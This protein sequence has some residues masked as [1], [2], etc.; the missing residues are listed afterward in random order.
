MD[1]D[2][3]AMLVLVTGFLVALVLFFWIF[4]SA[5]DILLQLGF[6]FAPLA[7]FAAVFL[8][9]FRIGH[10]AGPPEQVL[11]AIA[12]AMRRSLYRVTEEPGQLTIRIGSISAVKV[13]ARA[14]AGGTDLTYTPYGTTTGWSLLMVM[15]FL[16]ELAVFTAPVVLFIL[17]QVRDFVRGR[18]LPYVSA[19]GF[20]PAPAPGDVQAMLIDGLSEGHRLASEAV[21]AE[22]SSYQ[23][24]LVFGFFLGFVT[25]ALV[26]IMWFLSSAESDF[27]LRL[28]DSS[29]IALAVGA[30]VTVAFG[31]GIRHVFRP[32]L[33]RM[34]AWAG[35]LRE[36]LERETGWAP[37]QETAP[38]AFEIVSEA[39]GEV[40]LW[41]AALRRGG[42]SREPGTWAAILVAAFWGA[43]LLWL[44]VTL[45]ALSLL[46]AVPL[47]AGGFGLLSLAYLLYRG[48]HRKVETERA[49]AL[50]TWGTRL[51]SIRAQMERFL[52][53][54]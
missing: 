37:P 46:I 54:L 22:Q 41:L 15:F 50:S 34:K 18:I 17:V 52:Q 33:L 25:W 9:R 13:R 10:V 42:L 12:H 29:L 23:D 53:D 2:I 8:W 16:W 14:T 7:L 28:Q 40:P 49:N 44:A 39:T 3:R 47:G 31:L 30:A 38:S 20:P 48:W 27:A 36:A 21:E 4:T 45:V 24:L 51:S 5:L 19:G 43:T 11:A 6:V 1:R 26:F 35:R 32:R